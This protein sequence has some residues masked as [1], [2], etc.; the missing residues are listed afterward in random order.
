MFK[1]CISL[2][3]SHLDCQNFDYITYFLRKKPTQNFTTAR[4]NYRFIKITYKK[5]NDQTIDTKMIKDALT[6]NA[7]YSI[8]YNPKMQIWF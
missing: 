2:R 6:N 5:K 4:Y 3:T 8:A 1:N 7:T